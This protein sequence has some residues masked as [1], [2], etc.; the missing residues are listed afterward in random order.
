MPKKLIEQ[1]GLFE[2]GPVTPETAS[3]P[4]PFDNQPA[5]FYECYSNRER[6]VL[7]WLSREMTLADLAYSRVHFRHCDVEFRS[8][9]TTVRKY[10]INRL[11]ENSSIP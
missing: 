8:P 9:T 10:T 6:R 7:T 11:D 4:D 3:R 5:E 1:D 2:L